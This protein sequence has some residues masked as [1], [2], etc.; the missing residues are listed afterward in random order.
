[1]M[2]MFL[3]SN[4]KHGFPHFRSSS[5]PHSSRIERI[6]WI[7]PRHVLA[8]LTNA[9]TLGFGVVMEPP[10]DRFACSARQGGS[11]G[12]EVSDA[13][14]S[15]VACE[16]TAHGSAWAEAWCQTAAA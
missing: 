12:S 10:E 14:V 11:R 15:T 9:S 3:P 8:R 7:S 16:L 6:F 1:M 13:L 4:W 2:A 5:R